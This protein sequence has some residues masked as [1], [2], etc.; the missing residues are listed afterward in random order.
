MSRLKI[1]SG[2]PYKIV[3]ETWNTHTSSSS[4][5]ALL[6]KA[7][8][9]GLNEK[10]ERSQSVPLTLPASYSLFLLRSDLKCLDLQI[11]QFFLS[12]LLSDGVSRLLP[13]NIFEIMWIAVKTCWKDTDSPVKIVGYFGSRNFLHSD[14]LRGYVC[15]YVSMYVYEYVRQ[16]AYTYSA[17]RVPRLG[18]FRVQLALCKLNFTMNPCPL[19][20]YSS[21][22]KGIWWVFATLMLSAFCSLLQPRESHLRIS[23]FSWW[24]L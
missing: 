6:W 12:T 2:L 7:A 21:V 5:E 24:V 17:H 15:M 10:R 4:Q 1:V 13:W 23:H 9:R 3:I 16:K 22:P 14:L 19:E 20:K 18:I 11:G 8:A